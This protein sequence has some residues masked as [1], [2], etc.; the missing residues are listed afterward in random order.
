MPELPEVETVRMG[1]LP[2][3]EGHK[4]T[5]VELRRGDLR[6]AFPKDFAKR[7]T[8]RRVVRLWRRAKYL[9]AELDR[10]ETLVIHLG[11]SGRLSIGAEGKGKHDHVVMETDA[12]A[13]IVFTDHRR[14][15]LMTLVDTAKLDAD[16]LFKGL[17]VEPLSGDFD[18]GYLAR[19]LKG[20]KTPIK[21]ALLDQRVI[22]GLGNIYVCEALFR[23]GISPKRLAAKVKAVEP[24]VAAIKTVLREAIKAGGSS[25]RD[26]KKADGELGYFQHHFA[27]YDRA[28]E[29]CPKKGCGGT[30]KR[31]VQSGRSTF[32]CS[33]CQR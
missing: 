25:L 32:Y 8:G 26:Y 31:L 5:K 3:L 13:R 21:S 23:A 10:G 11:M 22:A 24:L 12:P 1:L 30:I 15:G 33:K 2:V 28:G 4:F 27:V 6:V 16:K 20:K 18:A 19:V 7:L 14:F 17:G 9:L 29:P